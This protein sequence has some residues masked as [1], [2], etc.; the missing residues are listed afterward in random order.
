M[1]KM[2]ADDNTWNISSEKVILETRV[3]DVVSAS[4]RC[5]RTGVDSSFYRLQFGDWVNIIALTKQQEIVLIKQFRFG[6]Q[7]LETEIPGGMIENGESPVVAGEREL[8]EETGYAGVNGRIIGTVCP[9]PAIQGNRCYTILVEDAEKVADQRMDDMEDISVKIVPLQEALDY[10][11]NGEI[12]HGLVLN[13]FF[14]LQ[15]ELR[16]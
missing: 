11:E 6:S 10:A 13:A 5:E 9:N 8:L 7:Q 1:S 3:G 4:V 14:F 15:K 12:E 2:G 16:K